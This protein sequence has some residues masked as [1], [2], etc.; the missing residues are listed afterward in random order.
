MKHQYPAGSK[1]I[2]FSV[3]LSPYIVRLIDEN[4]ETF[5]A[6][7][8]SALIEACLLKFLSADPRSAKSIATIIANRDES[9]TIDSTLNSIL[10]RAAKRLQIRP[11]ALARRILTAALFA[12]P[13]LLSTDLKPCKSSAPLPE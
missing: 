9:V 7:S 3:S 13:I 5:G 8:R 1:R 11:D 10:K 6:R 4:L 12:S 2:N